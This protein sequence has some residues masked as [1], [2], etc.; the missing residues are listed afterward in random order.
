LRAEKEFF[1]EYASVAYPDTL[2]EQAVAHDRALLSLAV[3][4][5]NVR[6]IDNMVV[7]R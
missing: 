3:F 2:Q 4:F 5:D 6:L 1:E 7:E